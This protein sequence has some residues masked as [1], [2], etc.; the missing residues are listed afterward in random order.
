MKS[1]CPNAKIVYFVIF[2]LVLLGLAKN[3]SAATYYVDFDSGNDSNSGTSQSAPWKHAPGDPNATGAPAD[4]GYYHNPLQPGDNILLKGGVVYRG[5]ITIDGRWTNGAPANPITFKGD[6]WGT[7]KAILDGSDRI[8]NNFTRCPSASDCDGNPNWQ[9]IYYQDFPGKNYTY[10][11]GFYEDE[12]F[13]WYAQDP[14]PAD[15]FIYDSINYLRVIRQNDPSIKYTRTSVTDP[16]YFTQADSNYWNGAYVIAWRVPNVT[17]IRRITGYDP[18][19]HTIYNEDVGGD[20]YTDR[21]SYYSVLNHVTLIDTP[22]EVS[23]DEA[24]QRLYVWPRQNTINH[25]YSLRNINL[26]TG[27]LVI[28]PVILLSKALLCRNMP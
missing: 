10:D 12:N 24:R 27:F 1:Y 28:A 18:A 7:G 20:L 22:G 9:N 3:S 2:F 25:S 19:S 16:R 14:N 4:R 13:L 23:Y 6:G 26:G 8:P 15:P 5:T 11:Q 21:D 17:V